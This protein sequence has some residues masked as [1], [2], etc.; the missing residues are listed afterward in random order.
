MLHTRYVSTLG[1]RTRTR[2]RARRGSAKEALAE[3][4][5][6]PRILRPVGKSV[7]SFGWRP[8]IAPFD[9]VRRF[10]AV[11]GRTRVRPRADGPPAWR[12]TYSNVPRTGGGGA[13]SRGRLIRW[14]VEILARRVIF[15]EPVFE[16]SWRRWKTDRF[17]TADKDEIGARLPGSRQGSSPTRRSPFL[18]PTVRYTRL[19]CRRG[20]GTVGPRSRRH[21]FCIPAARDPMPGGQPGMRLRPS[22][23]RPAWRFWGQQP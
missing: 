17:P 3:R 1:T 13:G 8:S 11:P 19:R 4:I 5:L 20:L 18:N 12:E 14:A 7:P 9:L 6:P 22:C 2:H 21:H 16:I 15:R 10:P 23:T